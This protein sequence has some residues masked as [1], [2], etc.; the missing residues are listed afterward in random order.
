MLY[1]PQLL[2]GATS[3]YPF[4]KQQSSRTVAG[5]HIDG[6]V[7]KLLDPY[8]AK[9][10]WRLSFT[11]LSSEERA[12]LESLFDATEGRLGEFTFLDPAHNLL[13]WSEQLT[14]PAW[15]KEPLI[16]LAEGIGDPLGTNRAT[17]ISNAGAATQRIDQ[18]I[19]APA[20][21]HYC[22]SFYARS[23][24]A[25]SI[26][27]FRSTTVSEESTVVSTDS[28][29]RRVQQAGQS[30]SAEEAVTFGIGLAPGGSVEVYGLQV[31]AQPGPSAYRMTLTRSGIH[32]NARFDDDV[33]HM[34]EDAPDQHSCL[35]RV[36]ARL[37]G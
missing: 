34:I 6:S 35:V 2:S 1:F 20:W 31:E 29:W 30:Q 22:F 3:Q 25:S 15:S 5:G 14:S 13:F 27:I 10:E 19:S 8:W 12:A 26:S 9:V 17:Q 37:T 36:V 18:T 23:D 7:S 33:L 21:F 28:S 32:A 11:G 24:Q 4:T 16:Q